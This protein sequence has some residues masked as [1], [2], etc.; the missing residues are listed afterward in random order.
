MDKNLQTVLK[1]RIAA[2]SVLTHSLEKLYLSTFQNIYKRVLSTNIVPSF[3]EFRKYFVLNEYVGVNIDNLL[4]ETYNLIID[5]C[6]TNYTL[7]AQK[8]KQQDSQ[9]ILPYINSLF[10]DGSLEGKLSKLKLSIKMEFEAIVAVGLLH[11]QSISAIMGLYKNNINNPY[12]IG[13][14]KEV[15]NDKSA[16]VSTPN[17][18]T[19]GLFWGR[20]YSSSMFNN[21]G[22]LS[23]N[24]GSKVFSHFDNQFMSRMGY[25]GYIVYR[26]SNYPCQA[27]DDNTGYHPIHQETL[28]V[29]PNCL[30]YALPYIGR[31]QEH[32]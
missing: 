25:Q 31:E 17:L 14:V 11:S 2:N 1:N 32:A 10:E 28:P 18:M 27:C 16:N 8:N 29:H 21:L 22:R 4:K 6:D 13:I 5:L 3:F 30:C 23:R 15:I 9:D 12:S 26:G 7:S 24:T 19:K 20:G